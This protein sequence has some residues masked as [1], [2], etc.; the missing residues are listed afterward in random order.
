MFRVLFVAALAVETILC[1]VS[2]PMVVG[3]PREGLV[4]G[5]PAEGPTSEDQYMVYSEIT[6]QVDHF[7]NNSDTW[8]QRYQYN[9]KFYNKTVGYVFL[10]LGGEGS[11]NVTNGDKWVRHE[12]ETMMTWAAEFQAGAFQVEHRFYGSK[13]YSPLGDQSTASLKLLTIDQALADVKEFITQMNALYFKDDKPIWI[14]FGGSYPGSLSAWFRET[15]PEMTAGAVSSSSAVHVFVDYYGYAINTEKTYRTVSDSCA[16]V[17]GAAFKKIVAKAYNGAD[18]RALLKQQF[19][20]CDSFDENNLSKSLQF[21]FQNIYGYF[22]G[23]NQYTGDNRN[24]ATR[25]GLGVPAACNILNNATIGDEIQRVI[26]VMDFYDSWNPPGNC[27]PNNYSSF[28]EYY[29]N[30]TMPN[31]DVISTR[32]WIWQTCTEL[33]YYQTTDGGNQGIFG[34]TVPLDFFADQCIDLFGPEY[35]LDNTFTLVDQVRAKYGGADAYRGTKVCFPNGSFDPWQGLGHKVNITN[36]DVDSWLIDG[37]AHCADMYPA[38]DS[39]VQSLKDARKRIHDHLAKWLADAQDLRQHDNGSYGNFSIFIATC[40]RRRLSIRRITRTVTSFGMKFAV[41]L[42]ALC[43]VAVAQIGTDNCNDAQFLACNSRLSDFWRTDTSTAWKDLSSLDRITQSLIVSPYTIDSWVNVCNGFSAFYGCLG[44]AQIRNCLGTVGLVAAGRSLT[45]AYA[46]Q[47]FLADWDFKCGV[48]F[49]TIYERKALTTCIESTYVNYQQDISAALAT[50]QIAV[51]QHPDNA[52]TYAQTFMN[53]WQGTYQKG[54]C[55]TVNPAQAGWFGC[56]SAREW[57]NAQFRHCQHTTTC[58]SP[59][60]IDAVTRV[61][62]QT[63]KTEYQAIPF[64][65]IVNNKAVLLE[66]ASWLSE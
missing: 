64:Y 50:Y 45:D 27:R 13:E 36:N 35:T 14:T 49:W 44:Q 55:R 60:T 47:G 8:R 12:G 20:L 2:P 52:C 46:Y 48:G 7:G 24:N 29:S 41:F 28:I 59:T 25:S 62:S 32:S 39:D 37:T 56:Q 58:A 11:I 61:N 38:R 6:Q 42:V 9:S 63:G 16:D 57:S 66:E 54:P 53:S 18:S 31:D 51:T 65:Q 15:Y 22:Q 30:T 21:F 23:I 3:R 40:I 19:N 1:H 4:R 10:M 26:A 43:G 34:S 17:I 33:G 5:D